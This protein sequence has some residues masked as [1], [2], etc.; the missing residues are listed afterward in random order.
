MNLE[1]VQF[2]KIDLF[3]SFFDSLKSDYKEFSEWFKKKQMI[4]HIYLK[5]IMV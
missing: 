1:K 3:D 5:I 4:S 2:K